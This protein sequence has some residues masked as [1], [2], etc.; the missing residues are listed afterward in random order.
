MVSTGFRKDDAAERIRKQMAYLKY[1]PI[2]FISALKGQGIDRLSDLFEEMLQQRAVKLATH[3]F[4]EWVRTESDVHNPKNARFYMCHQAG[5]HPPTF[6]CH[7]N[8]PRKIPFSLK[9]HL[10]NGIRL[11]WGYL[12][13]PIRMVFVQ[14]KSGR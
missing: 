11:R 4:T 5:R 8:D 7:V 9:R 13:S 10:V 1:A 2:V 14:G 6:V 3:E 12:G